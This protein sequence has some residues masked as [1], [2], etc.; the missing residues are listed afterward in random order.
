MCV[1]NEKYNYNEEIGIF[2][3]ERLKICKRGALIIMQKKSF[4]FY[5]FKAK[6]YVCCG[7][8]LGQFNLIVIFDFL[9]G[10]IGYS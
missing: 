2:F 5:C 3:S 4:N 10:R 1:K 7:D 8:R 6:K 9:K